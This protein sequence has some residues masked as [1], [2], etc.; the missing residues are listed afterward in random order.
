VDPI[1]AIPAPP[2]DHTPPGV[3]SVSTLVLPVHTVGVP[4]I[5][6]TVGNGFTVTLA[7]LAHPVVAV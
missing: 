7:N 6:A 5:A 4:P 2:V 3:A 1:V